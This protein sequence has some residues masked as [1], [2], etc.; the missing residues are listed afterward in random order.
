M[1]SFDQSNRVSSKP[2]DIKGMALVTGVSIPTLNRLKKAGKLPHHKIGG[3]VIFTYED[4]EQ[5]LSS[6]KVE[7]REDK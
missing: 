4:V 7:A 5:F 1:S 3:R 2:I 6:C